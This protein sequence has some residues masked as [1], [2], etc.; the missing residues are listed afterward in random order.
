M[1][2]LAKVVKFEFMIPWLFTTSLPFSSHLASMISRAQDGR[3]T[4]Q[5]NV[6]PELLPRMEPPRGTT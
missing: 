2:V 6:D 1:Q 3:T 5:V 4:R